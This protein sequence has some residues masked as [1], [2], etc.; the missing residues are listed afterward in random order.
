MQTALIPL[1]SS[2]ACSCG[3][4]ALCS[5]C[6]L[7]RNVPVCHLAWISHK[8]LSFYINSSGLFHTL[9]SWEALINCPLC[10][11]N[12]F[13]TIKISLSRHRNNPVCRADYML[14]LIRALSSATSPWCPAD[15]HTALL[16]PV[17]LVLEMCQFSGTPLGGYCSPLPR[18]FLFLWHT[19]TCSHLSTGTPSA[20][21]TCTKLPGPSAAV[22]ASAAAQAVTHPWLQNTLPCL[23][24]SCLEKLILLHIVLCHALQPSLL[25]AHPAGVCLG[26]RRKGCPVPVGKAELQPSTLVALQQTS[27]VSTSLGLAY[28]TGQEQVTGRRSQHKCHS[29]RCQRSWLLVTV[30]GALVQSTALRFSLSSQHSKLAC[31]E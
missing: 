25:P 18:L 16:Q 21:Y 7:H 11:S 15:T 6:C 26:W 29:R 22:S 13:V 3:Y 8:G 28:G 12:I 4:G 2:W 27:G 23:S 14:F 5:G 9:S 31:T 17:S 30:P 1:C 20:G 19:G 24:E 10:P